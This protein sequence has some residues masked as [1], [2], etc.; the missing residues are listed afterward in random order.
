MNEDIPIWR[1]DETRDHCEYSPSGHFVYNYVDTRDHFASEIPIPYW[2]KNGYRTK[3]YNETVFWLGHCGHL[4]YEMAGDPS[5]D[6]LQ[7]LKKLKIAEA[8][9]KVLTKRMDDLI[10][11][12]RRLDAIQILWAILAKLSVF[13]KDKGWTVEQIDDDFVCV[14]SQF[15]DDAGLPPQYVVDCILKLEYPELATQQVA[16][17][18]LSPSLSLSLCPFYRF[19]VAVSCAVSISGFQQK[20][21]S[22]VASLPAR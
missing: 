4:L 5:A 7:K 2:T 20:G 11:H 8:E 3:C 6:D 9:G 12:V 16:T 10:Q 21:V 1:G 22:S 15:M 14:L 17:R 18:C 19:R 13:G